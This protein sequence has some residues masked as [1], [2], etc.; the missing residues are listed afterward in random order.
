[1]KKKDVS[2]KVVEGI[3]AAGLKAPTHDHQRKWEFI[4]L[5][6]RQ[7]KENALQFVK[8][9]VLHRKKETLF[10]LWEQHAKNVCLCYAEA[11]YHAAQCA[12]CDY[13]F[14]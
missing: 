5:H 1:M 7:E 14:V 2:Q 13:P 10:P 12:I 3:I 4:V 9:G 6:N 8:A 11:I